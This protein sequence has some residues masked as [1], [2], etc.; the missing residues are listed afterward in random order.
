MPT[1]NVLLRYPLLNKHALKNPTFINL[2][3]LVGKVSSTKSQQYFQTNR[4]LKITY[5]HSQ[6]FLY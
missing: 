4:F 5:F 3:K 2:I 6:N 1:I